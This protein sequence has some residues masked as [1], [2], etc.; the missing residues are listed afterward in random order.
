[1][2]TMS[3]RGPLGWRSSFLA[4]ASLFGLVALTSSDEFAVGAPFILM[5]QLFGWWG[6]FFASMLIWL[7][8]GFVSLGAFNFIWPGVRSWVTEWER[9]LWV[10]V[11]LGLILAVGLSTA[12]YLY[13]Y[14]LIERVSW[15]MIVV[16]GVAALVLLALMA[17]IRVFGQRLID[18]SVKAVTDMG[19][20]WKLFMKPVVIVLVL[21]YMGPALS[22]PV[23][24]VLSVTRKSIY[25]LTVVAAPFFTIV[26][27]PFYTGVW[28]AVTER[29]L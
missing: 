12:I 26:W 28:S 11:L 13:R 15:E 2:A 1:M 21:V 16:L 7:L 19:S 20:R 9:H 22:H 25:L 23:L 27:Y 17:L 10:I 24:S 4:A 8:V 6:G 14:A 29:L 5:N 3:R 18:W